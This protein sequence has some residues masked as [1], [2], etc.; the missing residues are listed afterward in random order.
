MTGQIVDG[1]Q[2]ILEEI[3]V[4]MVPEKKMVHKLKMQTNDQTEKTVIN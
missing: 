1:N 4:S 2:V 3:H